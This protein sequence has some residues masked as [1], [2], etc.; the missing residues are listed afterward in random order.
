MG[1]PQRIASLVAARDLSFITPEREAE[2]AALDAAEA[3]R[4]EHERRAKIVQKLDL[5][6]TASD[7]R[8]L[9]GNTL[10]SDLGASYPAVRAWLAD[11]DAPAWIVLCGSKGRGKSLAG[12]AAV[13]DRGGRY[14]PAREAERLRMAA[15]GDD[16]AKWKELLNYRGLLVLD[17]LGREDSAERMTTALLDLVDF[18]RRSGMRTIAIANLTEQKLRD[19]YP[20]ERLWSRIGEC[21]QWVKDVGPDL[22]A[23]KP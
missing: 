2:L 7:E 20:D 1:N 17:D 21:A 3:A 22:R 10:R 15:F 11:A 13:V 9:I 16:E 18:R 14:V 4:K 19:R 5:P 12:L 23:V 8:M 6:I